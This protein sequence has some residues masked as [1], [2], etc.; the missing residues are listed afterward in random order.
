V[1]KRE[2]RDVLLAWAPAVAWAGVIFW[3]SSRTKTSLPQAAN[4]IVDFTVKKTAHLAEYGILA[5]L[6]WRGFSRTAA[7]LVS[8]HPWAILGLCALYSASDEF[9]QR[10]TPGRESSPRDVLIDIVGAGLG[11][12]IVS[13]LLAQRRRNPL[14]FRRFPW[15]DRF[16]S[17]LLPL[18]LAP[19]DDAAE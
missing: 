19:Q 2:F 6:V 3:W 8:R 17:G 13:V 18:R 15:L 16:L 5:V 14:W 1:T 4:D 12:V 7:G 10:F 11:L 9:H